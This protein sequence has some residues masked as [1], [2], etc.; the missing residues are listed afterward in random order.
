MKKEL[1]KKIKAWG[2]SLVIT[3]NPEE[4]DLIGLAEGDIL[5]LTITNIETKEPLE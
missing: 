5:D 1:T 2:N 4:R 3:F